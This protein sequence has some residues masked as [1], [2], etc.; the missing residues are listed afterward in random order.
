MGTTFGLILTIAIGVSLAIGFLLFTNYRG[1]Q[2]VKKFY[3]SIEIGDAWKD[4]FYSN[5]PFSKEH[6]VLQVLAK[7]NNYVL[8]DVLWY[9]SNTHH[10]V[11]NFAPRQESCPIESFYNMV[12]DYTKIT[13]WD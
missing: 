13:L 7:A 10:R 9:D 3:D 5:E 11:T 1:K 2:K 12:K 8:Y 4:P 6:R